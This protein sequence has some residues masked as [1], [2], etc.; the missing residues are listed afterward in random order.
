MSYCGKL[1][2]TRVARLKAAVADT[3]VLDLKGTCYW[4]PDAPADC[5]L[6]D[7]GGEKRQLLYWDEVETPGY[8]IRSDPKPHHLGFKRCWKAVNHLGLVALPDDG[9][10][11]K[12]RVQVPKSWYIKRAVQSE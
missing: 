2:P 4:V 5:L 3:G 6:V 1:S 8:G 9:E 11:I 12:E 7:L 10:A